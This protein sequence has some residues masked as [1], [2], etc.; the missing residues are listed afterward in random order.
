M[1]ASFW[2]GPL[3]LAALSGCIHLPGPAA[4][5][6]ETVRFGHFDLRECVY[7]LNG[8]KGAIT[9]VGCPQ[10]V[11]RSDLT[12][13][14]TWTVPLPANSTGLD[15]AFFKDDLA[16]ARYALTIRAGGHAWTTDGLGHLANDWNAHDEVPRGETLAFTF[17]VC[18]EPSVEVELTADGD[19]G[20]SWW[21]LSVHLV[22]AT[23]VAYGGDPMGGSSCNGDW[24]GDPIV[25]PGTLPPPQSPNLAQGRSK[26][27]PAL[28]ASLPQP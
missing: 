27:H 28:P 3:V 10:T 16:T 6:A 2:M 23:A 17:S 4:E 20:A 1:N 19:M 14:Q 9:I 12:R 26:A 13:S 11:A 8:A 21:A 5:T 18:R 22:N 25:P 15:L 24:T 7:A